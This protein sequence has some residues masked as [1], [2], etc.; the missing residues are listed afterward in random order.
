MNKLDTI[1]R[2]Q[3]VAALVEG[4]SIRAT[5]RMTGV[6]KNTIAKLLVELGTA[7]SDYMN[8][9]LVNLPCKRIQA[10]E[11]WSFFYA[12]EKNVTAE[13]T[14]KNPHAGDVWTWVAIDADTKLICS[15]MVGQRDPGTA[16]E[17]M[18]DLSS[19]LANRLQ[20][21][22][23]GLKMYLTAVDASFGSH[24]DYAML[25]K[26]YGTD[27]EGQKR[28][29][30]AQC[31]GCETKVVVGNPNAKHINTSYVERQNLTMRMSMRRFLGLRMASARRSKT[32]LQRWLFIT[33]ITISSGFTRLSG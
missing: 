25:V 18:N 9:N 5:V 3:I 7:C 16:Y 24:I 26:V 23:D 20:L 27:V 8:K 12:K 31:I 29:S 4:N 19:R 13:I 14:A 21:T 32:T 10:D 22:T 28:Y 33:C 1:K 11:I 17:F 2:A 6:A 15:W 30:P